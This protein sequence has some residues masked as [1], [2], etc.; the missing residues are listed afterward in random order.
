MD[1]RSG[2]HAAGWR[3][4]SNHGA[5]LDRLATVRW[6][7]VC[8]H[9]SD[10]R[11]GSSGAGRDD[12][13]PTLAPELVA[14]TLE[15][16][17][18]S[19]VGQ[20]LGKSH[21]AQLLDLAQISELQVQAPLVM[22]V[23]DVILRSEPP[24]RQ[25]AIPLCSRRLDRVRQIQT[26]DD[27]AMLPAAIGRHAGPA[28]QVRS[29]RN[30]PGSLR[31]AS[32]PRTVL[33]LAPVACAI[34]RSDRPAKSWTSRASSSKG[35]IADTVGHDRGYVAKPSHGK[36]LRHE[37]AARAFDDS[38]HDLTGH[39]ARDR[40]PVSTASGPARVRRWRPAGAVCDLR[41]SCR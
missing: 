20:W 7:A 13:S 3:W 10:E 14:E 32:Q 29:T 38:A 26:W 40:R 25:R 24:L 2:S 5:G 21:P 12:A 17:P 33:G 9:T 34:S 15:R 36:T 8:E 41:S 1:V 18:R 30:V 22:V 11:R 28:E 35:L 23:G 4:H 6:P 27:I 19:P 39:D 31:P 37:A 16:W